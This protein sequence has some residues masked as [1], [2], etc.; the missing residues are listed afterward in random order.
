[1]TPVFSAT[2]EAMAWLSLGIDVGCG[3]SGEAA[4]D[5]DAMS[6]WWRDFWCSCHSCAKYIL[7]SALLKR[8]GLEISNETGRMGFV[9]AW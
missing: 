9:V 1:M 7:D 3:A 5:V 8:V 4:A 6:S 2:G